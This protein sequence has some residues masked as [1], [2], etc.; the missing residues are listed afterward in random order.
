MDVILLETNKKIA[1]HLFE[2]F[3]ITSAHKVRGGGGLVMG[4]YNV[5]V[6]LCLCMLQLS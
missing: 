3:S 4:P 2:Y 5:K 1:F 6:L